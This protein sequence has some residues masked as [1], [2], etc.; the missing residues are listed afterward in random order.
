MVQPFDL[1]GQRGW[2]GHEV[3]GEAS[4]GPAIRRLF[5]DGF[6][7]DGCE[8]DITAQLLPEPDNRHDPNAVK[9]V[10]AGSTVGYLAREEAKLYFP[11]LSAL[12]AGG[13]TPQARAYVR[14]WERDDDYDYRERGT[15]GGK[16]F[17]GSVSLDLA[18]PHLLVPANSPPTDTYAL[19]PQGGAIQVTGEE[20]HM[21][22]L[23]PLLKPE[24]STWVYATLHEQVEQ[25][26]RTT[27]QVVE[28]QLDGEPVGKLTP[29]MSGEV[30]PAV[31]HLDEYGA[32][33]SCRAILKGN[34]VKAD[35]MLHVA[36]A[37]EIP[38][39]WL[40]RPPLSTGARRG[41]V[42][43]LAADQLLPPAATHGPSSVPANASELAAQP[44]PPVAHWRFNAPPGWPPP[45]ADWA[46]RS[47]WQPDPSWPPAPPGWQWW[48]PVLA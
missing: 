40:D 37:N 43:S 13:Y 26:A 34:R 30:L 15:G 36:R 27:R 33:A 29:K 3:V 7:A 46:P 39:S 48:V 14:A 1:W 12:V 22:A 25:T 31:R 16:R 18:E 47:G 35:V 24:G 45:P 21:S 19:L 44:S 4:Y 6:K 9:V 28:V 8:I 10:C 41:V 2:A 20:E 42:G 17:V 32:R 23:I 11:V 38:Q 5:G